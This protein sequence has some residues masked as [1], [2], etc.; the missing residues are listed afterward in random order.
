LSL[1]FD[2]PVRL[3][4]LIYPALRSYSSSSV[5]VSALNSWLMCHSFARRGVVLRC[6]F[7]LPLP[8][9][10]T[11]PAMTMLPISITPIILIPRYCLHCTVVSSRLLGGRSRIVVI[12]LICH[13]HPLYTFPI[14]T[15]ISRVPSTPSPPLQLTLTF[16]TAI[17]ESVYWRINVVYHWG[18]SFVFYIRHIYTTISFT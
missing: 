15:S 4:C 5:P 11:Q 12:N 9:T 2:C 14:P 16:L 10:C 7:S 8:I 18:Q 6:T 17:I 13:C 1:L 3:L